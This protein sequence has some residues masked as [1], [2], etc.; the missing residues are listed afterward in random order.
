MIRSPWTRIPVLALSVVLSAPA[1]AKTVVVPPLTARSTTAEAVLSMTTLMAS[2]LEFVGEFDEVKQLE[3]R[4]SGWGWGCV[5]S[6][7]CLGS[8]VRANGAQALVSG[9]VSKVGDR[10]ELTLVYYD[11]G[12][13]VRSEST[14][15]P[16]AP[17]AV[18]DG[19]SSHVRVAVTGVS[20]E[21]KAE[22]ERVGGF[23][24][25]AMGILDEEEE[26]DSFDFAT[27]PAPVS[28]R[29]TTPDGSSAYDEDLDDL[30]EEEDSRNGRG[31]GYAAAAVG[32][33]AAGAAVGYGA[34]AGSS[35]AAAGGGAAGGRSAGGAGGGA[36]GRSGGGGGAGAGASGGAAA[37]AGGAES[38]DPNAIQFGSSTDDISVES[39]SF[40]SAASMIQVDD[41]RGDSGYDEDP[42]ADSPPVYED[43]DDPQPTRSRQA[44]RE[45]RPRNRSRQVGNNS[46]AGT[47][48]IAGRMGFTKFQALN[49]FTYGFEGS[50]QI[51]D[52]LAVVAGLEAHSTRRLLDP[53]KVP[54]GEP[55]IEW[56][57]ILP[58][59]LG[60]LYRPTMGSWRPYGGAGMQF[61]PGY[62]KSAGG[63]AIGLRAR[64]GLDY[65]ITDYLGLN[66]N[67][68]LGMWTGKKF[69]QVQD[70][71]KKAGFVP[72]FSGGTVFL[73]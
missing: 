35:G 2:E 29:L 45:Q 63:M 17:S 25:G 27:A 66:V 69:D 72:Q 36:Y 42:M 55:A 31:G 22:A 19:I 33:A 68:A 67:L 47:F 13:I 18:A 48:G 56:N 57:T 70:G 41:G 1:M 12:R 38:F 5:K 20:P 40:G 62:V 73:F 37:G 64:G 4:P 3:R 8:I 43:L 9:T 14:S 6:T 51:Q 54:E 65:I 32:G 53:T 58:F 21:S 26:G 46:S 10:Y 50:Y 7:S 15:M 24:G 44:P 30:D 61:I 39:I 28:R 49:F 60:L 71:L 23:E 16:T 34:A 11:G 52:T 59:N